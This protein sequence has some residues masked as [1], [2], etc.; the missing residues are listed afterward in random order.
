VK[1]IYL[2]AA[3]CATIAVYSQDPV[4]YNYRS[5]NGL[6]SNEVYNVRADSRGWL[7]F[8]T[9]RGVARFDGSSFVTYSV[10]DGIEENVVTDIFTAPNGDVWIIADAK[11]LYR[12]TGSGFEAYPYNHIIA[13]VCGRPAVGWIW[14][15]SFEN[16]FPA[17][18]TLRQGGL[19]HIQ[20]GGNYRYDSSRY[21]VS[22]VE[23]DDEKRMTIFHTPQK[24]NVHKTKG[25]Y[26]FY[27]KGQA[28]TSA[29]TNATAY[30]RRK[31]GA[32]LISYG[33]C[34]FEIKNNRVVNNFVF[35]EFITNLYEDDKQRLW[36]TLYGAGV[37]M[38]PPVVFPNANNEKIYFP[39]IRIS[40][41]IQDREGGYWFSS[42][43]RG[44]YYVPNLEVTVI[45]SALFKTDE[46][47]QEVLAAPP[48]KV[49]AATSR[50]S[51]FEM[52][53]DGKP[54][55]LFAG[56]ELDNTQNCND[57]VYDSLQK[58]LYGCY[59]RGILAH[60]LQ[61]GHTK[62]Y[63]VSARSVLPVNN[64]FHIISAIGFMRNANDLVNTYSNGKFFCMYPFNDS[65]LLIGFE[66][67]LLL[68][69]Y[70]QYKHLYQTVLDRRVT[71][72]KK[73]ANGWLLAATLGKGLMLINNEQ[74]IQVSLGP[75][76]STNMVNDIAVSGNTVWAATES[77]IAKADL[78]NPQ[79][80]Q[81]TAISA[82][83]RFPYNNTRKIAY[84]DGKLYVLAQNRLIVF[85]EQYTL[86]AQA[87]PIWLRQ[88]IVGDSIKLT[89][90][91]KHA[92]NFNDKRF[93]FAFNGI[94]FKCGTSIRYQYRLIGLHSEWYYTG[95]PYVDY[96]S[97]EPGTYT[98]EVKAIS[99]DH[100]VSENAAV[101]TFTIPRPYWQKSWFI[102]SV[103]LL[104]LLLT[105][106][107]I[108]YLLK[109]AQLRNREKELLL[110]KEQV[111]L[112]AQINPHFI[113][114]SLNSIQHLII[115]EDRQ[116]AT[117]H[118]ASFS[119]LMR[120]SLDNSRK[121]WVAV[122]DEI[123]LLK[124]Y[125][126][127]ESLRFKDKFQYSIDVAEDVTNSAI[128]I[129]AML[130]QPFVENAVH[131]GINNLAGKKG[132]VTIKLGFSG[133]QLEARV[134]DNGIGRKKALA[135][136]N[137]AANH[138]SVGMQITEE[139]LLLLCKE[140][141]TTFVFNIIDKQ[142]EQGTAAGT[143]VTFNMPYLRTAQG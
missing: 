34:L 114:N 11:R 26:L 102:V 100:I 65:N 118:M 133:T 138:L 28:Y 79:K 76:N 16:N 126:E 54:K 143:L 104:G 60:N 112:S 99:D 37:R 36:V 21:H 23:E 109:K 121:K 139:R 107:L 73:L 129:P 53:P 29:N 83:N 6:P 57:L 78:S 24:R 101:Y 111:A 137:K 8:G 117:L 1:S 50:G 44:V 130:I 32:T 94:C 142:D 85:P 119:R 116:Q 123:E 19:L 97:L 9:D 7:W 22:T 35:T 95:Q 140:T 51:I 141:G 13:R 135:L 48:G 67:G 84:L 30:L 89:P 93:R 47:F 39:S 125:L 46:L 59:S 42:Y 58:I 98:F 40:C 87:P 110:A 136:Q 115:Q 2:L 122:N 71:A 92:F 52:Q 80:P 134:E 38:Y 14:Q 74:I 81:V 15:V 128:R 33:N 90:D 64:E 103:V 49:Y 31:N 86:N 18:F 96:P 132:I 56:R 82:D 3:L 12:Y 20:P 10:N 91:E 105:A 61:T 55:L 5:N 113:F 108:R 25:H 69:N 131:H 72:I 66:R 124:L 17:W 43:D 68:Y 77:G 106:L 27:V 120:L 70:R 4:Y 63:A 62:S 45:E 127:L 41:I 75:T 88:V